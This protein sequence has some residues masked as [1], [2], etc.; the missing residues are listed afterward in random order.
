ML[1]VTHNSHSTKIY[2]P[3]LN[4][5][6]SLAWWHDLRF[7]RDGYKSLDGEGPA[8]PPFVLS[9]WSI[10]GVSSGSYIVEK[11]EENEKET[12]FQYTVGLTVV[13]YRA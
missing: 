5:L 10:H 9:R 1:G 4:G 2:L 8:E 7:K 12:A 3:L 13:H 6:S 11:E